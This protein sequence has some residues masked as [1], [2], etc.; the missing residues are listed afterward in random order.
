MTSIREVLYLSYDGLTD[1]LGQSQILPYL[2]GL[3]SNGN[4]FIVVSFEKKKNYSKLKDE[5][6]NFCWKS[7]ITWVPHR[8]HKW[9]PV[10][11]T[12]FDL[13]T[14]SKTVK[15]ILD[16]NRIAIIHCRSYLTSLVGLEAKRRRNVKF[17]FDMRGFWADERVEGGLW[18][19]KNPIYK[20]IYKY[21]KGRERT[22][23]QE[24]DHVVSLTQ[25]A[26]IEIES[27]GF[28]VAPISVIPTC[29]DME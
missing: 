18:S 4:R 24:A 28:E 3:S 10:F 23:L 5:I 22:F 15:Q 20:A 21:F 8:Y 1:P 2:V 11:S 7:N 16:H 17:I 14:L 6:E 13:W 25:A 29:V 19:L 12:L 26:K 9:P 27:W